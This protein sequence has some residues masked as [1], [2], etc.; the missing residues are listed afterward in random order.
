MQTKKEIR[1]PASFFQL[2]DTASALTTACLGFLGNDPIV[3]GLTFG[4]AAFALSSFVVE[5]AIQKYG[6]HVAQTF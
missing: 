5:E 3:A 1:T 6:G 2:D 4:A